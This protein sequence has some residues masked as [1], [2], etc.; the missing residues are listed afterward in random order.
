MST[1]PA[2]PRGPRGVLVCYRR[3]GGT[4][5]W[6]YWGDIHEARAARDLL[7][8]CGPGCC[9]T[10][11]VVAVAVPPRRTPAPGRASQAPRQ[12]G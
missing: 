12:A 6:T 1:Q 9:G 7:P 5:E 2:Q 3:D 8:P 10:H 4:A 11:A